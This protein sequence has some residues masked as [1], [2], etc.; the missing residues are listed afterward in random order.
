MLANARYQAT[1]PASNFE[2]AKAFYADKL[3][4]TPASDVPAGAFYESNGTRFLL[5]PSSG[6]ASGTHTQLGFDVDDIAAT[7]KDLEGRGVHFEE[8]DFPG[9]DKATRIA[10]VG[11]VQSAWFKDTEGNLLGIVQLAED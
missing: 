2:R 7:V 1:L 8:Y 5:F 10:T 6:A 11:G 4:L 9:F 3:G